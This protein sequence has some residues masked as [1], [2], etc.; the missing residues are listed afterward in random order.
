MHISHELFQIDK[1]GS[2]GKTFLI[3]GLK[4]GNKSEFM[5]SVQMV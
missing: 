3:M 1:G 4:N 2:H 5:W